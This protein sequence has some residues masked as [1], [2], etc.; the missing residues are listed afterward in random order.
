M[1]QSKKR[2]KQN[3]SQKIIRTRRKLK[4]L[5][6]TKRSLKKRKQN[7]CSHVF[8]LQM[9]H[10]PLFA[11]YESPENEK[12]PHG[13]PL[14]HILESK[15]CKLCKLKPGKPPGTIWQICMRCWS[16]MKSLGKQERWAQEIET[17]QCTN[18]DC[19]SMT[20]RYL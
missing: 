10:D 18:P 20:Y 4:K 2:K 17:Y 8:V 12:M 16:P 5:L 1:S 11:L 13:L 9:K 7:K 6:G 3:L 14:G 19:C 15:Q